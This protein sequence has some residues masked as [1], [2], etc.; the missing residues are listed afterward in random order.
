MFEFAGGLLESV[1][2]CVQLAV[3]KAKTGLLGGIL[4]EFQRLRHV[5]GGAVEFLLAR[6]NQREVQVGVSQFGVEFDGPLED[7]K[8]C[9]LFSQTRKRHSAAV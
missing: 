6:E 2:L 1:S 3:Q 9:V 7:L 5:S 4:F 8:R